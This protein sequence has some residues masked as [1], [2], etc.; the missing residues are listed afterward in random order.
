MSG[1]VLRE[2]IEICARYCKTLSPRAGEVRLK[3][4]ADNAVFRLDSLRRETTSASS[5][6]DI[7]GLFAFQQL[8]QW[9]VGTDL[10]LQRVC[11]GPIERED[12]MPFLKLFRAPVLTGGGVY[13][14]EF[15]RHLL[16]LPVVRTPA[17]FPRFIK[18]YPCG[19]FDNNANDLPQQIAALLTAALRHEKALPTQEALAITLNIPLSTLRRNLGRAGTSYSQLKEACLRERAQDLLCEDNVAIGEVAARLGFSDTTSFRRAF[20]RWVG[21]SPSQWRA[22]RAKA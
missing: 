4:L 7:T 1:R 17:E 22:R 18:V 10:Q 9:L 21:R 14:L 15:P 3:L 16:D 11:I 2:S 13:T 20:R 12:V 19:V 6:I 8:F 5:L